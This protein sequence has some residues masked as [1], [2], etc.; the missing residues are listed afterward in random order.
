M[1][2]SSSSARPLKP[3]HTG[4][5]TIAPLKRQMTGASTRSATSTSSTG[6]PAP[7]RLAQGPGAS[8]VPAPSS[9]SS[10][11]GRPKSALGDHSNY[12]FAAATPSQPLKA[13]MTGGGGSRAR[14]GTIGGGGGGA[15]VAQTPLSASTGSN[16]SS[17]FLGASA[18]QQGMR[19]PAGWGGGAAAAGAAQMMSPS[20]GAPA[21]GSR[22]P[23][24]VP[25][26][27]GFRP[28]G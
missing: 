8:V 13:Q 16:G 2:A 17:S 26:S 6:P 19:I 3:Q 4:A 23:G 27:T 5:S 22:G 14:S 9:S 15:A 24:L 10:R 1:G 7:K 12:G 11:I 25:Q 20:L 21:A 18:G 28:R